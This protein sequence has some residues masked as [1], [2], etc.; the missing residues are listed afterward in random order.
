MNTYD[1]GFWY[2]DHCTVEN[3]FVCKRA[4]LCEDSSWYHGGHCYRHYPVSKTWENARDHCRKIGGELASIH[5]EEEN[6]F[7][8]SLGYEKVRTTT[9]DN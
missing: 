3:H 7:V 5:S 1:E 2:D 8:K 6:D 4:L 9:N